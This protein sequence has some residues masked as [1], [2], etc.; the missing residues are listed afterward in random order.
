MKHLRQYVKH[1]A[2]HLTELL[3]TRYKPDKQKLYVDPQTN[4]IT[5]GAVHRTA[6]EL[7]LAEPK[8]VLTPGQCTIV[9]VNCSRV[10]HKT[11]TVCEYESSIEGLSDRGLATIQ[12]SIPWSW[13]TQLLNI[14]CL[15]IRYFNIF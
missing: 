11:E 14:W 10:V 6:V 15:E 4:F 3:N 12:Y 9:G 2:K 5:A 7:T 8:L 1:E 13:Q